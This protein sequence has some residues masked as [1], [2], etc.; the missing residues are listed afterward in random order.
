[1]LRVGVLVTCDLRF[2][3]ASCDGAILP[4][5]LAR[6]DA[7]Y[8]VRLIRDEVLCADRFGGLVL[9]AHAGRWEPQMKMATREAKRLTGRELHALF[10]ELFPHGFASADVLAEIAPEGWEHS[11]LLACF[12]PSVEQ[13]FEERVTLHRNLEEWRQ[14]RR[15]RRGRDDGD[16]RSPNQRS[17]TCVVSTN[18]R[19]STQDEEVTELVGLCLWDVFSDNHDVIARGRTSW[20]TSDHF[21][22]LVR[23]WTST[24]RATRRVGETAT[25]CGS[26]WERS[27]FPDAPT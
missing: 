23:S 9:R 16:F 12:H 1:M 6:S 19:R 18:R 20:P 3:A 10:D 2:T 21:G 17:T 8:S 15:K 14:L 11:P 7:H 5:K 13:L 25:T 24:S 27:G 22:A 4:D 26:I